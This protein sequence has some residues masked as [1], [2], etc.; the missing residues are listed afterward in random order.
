LKQTDSLPIPPPRLNPP[1]WSL[2]CWLRIYFFPVKYPFPSTAFIVFF[3]LAAGGKGCVLFATPEAS[4]G[5]WK[6][7]KIWTPPPLTPGT[8]SVCVPLFFFSCFN[9]SLTPF[10]PPICPRVFQRGRQV[11]H[12]YMCVLIEA[13]KFFPPFFGTFFPLFG[14]SLPWKMLSLLFTLFFKRTASAQAQSFC[15]RWQSLAPSF[16]HRKRL[17][18]PVTAV[19]FT[20]LGCVQFFFCFCR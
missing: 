10:F 11:F 5:P 19:F 3:C 13:L 18:P 9:R 17:V 6:P 14:L 16:A 8:Q 20:G 12:F 1:P 7:Q 2:F 15:S 4:P